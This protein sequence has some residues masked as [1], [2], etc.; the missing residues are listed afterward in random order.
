MR[1]RLN[2]ERVEKRLDSVVRRA[3]FAAIG[4]AV[5]GGIG[6]LLSRNAA[7]TGAGLGALAGATVAEKLG[8]SEVVVETVK[9]RGDRRLRSKSEESAE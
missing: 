3:K 4:G 8:A 9:Q 6:G 5:G 2:R 1:E 7:S